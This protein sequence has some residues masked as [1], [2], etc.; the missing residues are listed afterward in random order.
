MVFTAEKSLKDAGDKVS[1]EIKTEVEEKIKA[2]KDI[3]ETGT[4]ED[5]EAKTKDLMDSLQKVG[6]A[7]YQQ[8]PQGDQPAS[9]NTNGAANSQAKDGKAEEGEVVN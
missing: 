4:K 3:L 2:V 9:D 6:A 8:Q 7:M 1:A 5:L